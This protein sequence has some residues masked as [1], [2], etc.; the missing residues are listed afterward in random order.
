MHNQPSINSRSKKRKLTLESSYKNFFCKK[1]KMS[2]N[3]IHQT[4]YVSI[5]KSV[6]NE[7]YKDNRLVQ[8]YV[9]C[10]DTQHID[11]VISN[12]NF[13]ISLTRDIMNADAILALKTHVKQNNKIR[14]IA[15][16]RQII[17]YTIGSVTHNNI[18]RALKE[19]LSFCV[20]FYLNFVNL[21]TSKNL[22]DFNTLSK[23]CLATYSLISHTETDYE[24]FNSSF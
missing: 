12:L 13:A 2:K 17:I 3:F 21:C 19:M 7:T 18:L 15:R 22:I 1:S 24:T 16:S 8:L 10:I 14:L 5:T 9:Y 11:S 23:T 4:N 6:S 20:I